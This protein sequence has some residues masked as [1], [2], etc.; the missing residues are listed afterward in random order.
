MVNPLPATELVPLRGADRLPLAAEARPGGGAVPVLLAHGFGQTRQSWSRTQER[1]AQAGHPSLSW[2]LRGHGESGRN[3]A[4][5]PYRAEQ[6]LDDVLAVAAHF[7]PGPKPVLVGASLGGLTGLMAQAQARPF[8]GL[9]LVDVTP[10]WEAAGV[11][12]IVGFMTAHPGGFDDLEHAADAIAAYLPHRHGRKRAAQLQHLL[13]RDGDGRLR[14]HWDPRLIGEFVLGSEHLQERISA[15]AGTID[16][17]VLLVSGGRSDIVSERTIAHFRSLVPQARHEQLAAAT[18]MVAGDDNDAF[19]A[20]LL[21]FLRANYP[22]AAAVT[23][24]PFPATDIPPVAV[25]GARA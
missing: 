2:D 9:V 11:E 17:P 5:V 13:R 1:L 21:R 20:A 24:P 22:P 19:S 10:R 12:R 6:F 15:A 4:A 16:V 14:W 8:A 3:A 25:S 7:A 23:A 18:H